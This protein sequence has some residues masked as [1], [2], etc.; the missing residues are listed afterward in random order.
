[1]A[2][3]SEPTNGYTNPTSHTNGQGTAHELPVIIAGGGCVGLFLAL[4]LAHSAIPIRIIV[5]E[6]EL[7][8]P[9]STRAMAHQPPTYP[10]LARVPGLL[11]ELVE[12]GCLS[13]GLCF[14]TAA[15]TGSKVIAGK[16]FDNNSGEA[17]MKG[18]GQLLLPQAKFQDVLMRRLEAFG[19]KAQVILQSRVVG[20]SESSTSVYVHVESRAGPEERLEAQYLIGADG[21]RSSV[22]KMMGTASPGE[23][24]D[25][26]L[27]ATDLHGFDFAKYG[28]YD[29]NFIIDPTD[30]GLIGRINRDG[31]WRVSYGVPA[32]LSEEEI[33]QGVDDKLRRMLPNDGVDEA[34]QKAYRVVRVAPYK[35]QQRCADTFWKGR[36]GIVGDA[37]HLTNP[38]AGL[39]LASGIADAS[40]LSSVLTRILGSEASDAD[41][42]L[43]S[44]S[45][46]RR[47][48]YFSVV[49][50]PSRMA[51]MRVKSDVGTPEKVD[52]LLSHDPLVGALKKGMP[53]MPPS[54]ETS[55]EELEGW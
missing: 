47:Q 52:A 48:K 6:L 22:R 10:I 37:A 14:R 3:T 2:T 46:A 26:Q 11:P 43:A 5:I 20:F 45:E 1:M 31:L 30:Y 42:L 36:V 35:A 40:S 21:A 29:A 55:V 27:V 53:M 13:S 16:A 32:G 33:K 17:G 9:T 15:A 28:F 51:Y 25:A 19:D 49:D 23:T 18:K 34:G 44:W 4:L 38:Y 7:P 41:K 39:G 12:T 24:L 8:D 54:L 50:K